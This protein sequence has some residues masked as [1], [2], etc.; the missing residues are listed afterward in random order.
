ML[1][2]GGKH[3]WWFYIQ[4]SHGVLPKLSIKIQYIFGR[5]TISIGKDEVF[6]HSLHL[7][8]GIKYIDEIDV[9]YEMK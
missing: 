8:I 4:E 9:K 5:E 6:C 7:K 2:L 1:K 3:L